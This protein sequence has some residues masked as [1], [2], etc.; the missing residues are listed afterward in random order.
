MVQVLLCALKKKG[1]APGKSCQPK[2]QPQI[3]DE[4]ESIRMRKNSTIRTSRKAPIHQLTEAEAERIAEKLAVSLENDAEDISLLVLLINHL[5]AVR[6]DFVVFSSST[7]SIKQKLFMGTIAMSDAQGQ[8]E[9]DALA[10]RNNLLMWP[11]EKV[12]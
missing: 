7:F 6:E 5:E 8:F 4:K 10:D 9:A 2:D 1:L 12:A 11:T 3:S